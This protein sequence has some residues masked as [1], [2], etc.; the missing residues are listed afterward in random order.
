MIQGK[1]YSSRRSAFKSLME[2]ETLPSK[3]KDQ[4]LK[5]LSFEV[6]QIVTQSLH[7]KTSQIIEKCFDLLYRAGQ[8]IRIFPRAGGSRED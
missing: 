1:K 8:N 7:F 5:C 4:M 2:K 6:K 3:E